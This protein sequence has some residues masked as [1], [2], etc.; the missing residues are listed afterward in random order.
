MKRERLLKYYNL[1]QE[2][3]R[4]ERTI[5]N[6]EFYEWNGFVWF[7]KLREE[8]SNLYKLDDNNEYS[9]LEYFES[10]CDDMQVF[11]FNLLTE[12]DKKKLTSKEWHLSIMSSD[13]KNYSYCIVKFNNIE[14][15]LDYLE[16]YN[17]FN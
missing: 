16:K 13:E 14:E 6:I 5:F 12:E 11:N 1:H 8:F 3:R 15:I 9:L 7:E 2:I 10:I 4:I 17:N